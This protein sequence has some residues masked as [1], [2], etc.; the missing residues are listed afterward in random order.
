MKNII[1]EANKRGIIIYP[2]QMNRYKN[3]DKN[4]LLPKEKLAKL[5]DEYFKKYLDALWCVQNE[6]AG[7]YNGWSSAH[8]I[9]EKLGFIKKE[10]SQGHRTFISYSYYE[11]SEMFKGTNEALN[12]LTII[13]DV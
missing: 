9:F 2:F 6:N 10:I 8:K 11:L 4:H 13:S 1:K 12:K 5:T 7:G 3:S